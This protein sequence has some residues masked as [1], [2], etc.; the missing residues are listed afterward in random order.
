M[1]GLP[2]S[3]CFVGRVAESQAIAAYLQPLQPKNQTERKVLIIQ[4]HAGMG[5]TQLSI[6]YCRQYHHLYSGVFW[7]DCT[8]HDSLLRSFTGL[9]HRI[10]QDELGQQAQMFA[11]LGRGDFDTVTQEILD[12]FSLRTNFQWLIVFDNVDNTFAGSDSKIQDY[13]PVADQGG[14]LF[15]CYMCMLILMKDLSSC[16]PKAKICIDW[17]TN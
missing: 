7:I 3:R 5:K 2:T 9:A 8:T 14:C 12:W 10:P 17:V 13:F 1:R 11:R 16:P 6:Q 4:A 15:T